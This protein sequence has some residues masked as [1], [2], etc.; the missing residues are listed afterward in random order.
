[1]PTA[2]GQTTHFQNKNILDEQ[3]EVFFHFSKYQNMTFMVVG[4]YI[5]HTLAHTTQK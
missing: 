3:G 1:M 4:E 5:N 2:Y